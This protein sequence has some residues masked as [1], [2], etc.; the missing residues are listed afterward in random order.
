MHKLVEEC[1]KKENAE[2]E[3]LIKGLHEKAENGYTD[4]PFDNP[5]NPMQVNLRETQQK[6]PSKP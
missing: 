2:I 1:T 3:K 4:N 6:N 5:L